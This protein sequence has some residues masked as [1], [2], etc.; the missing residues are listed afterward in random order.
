MSP[1]EL[2]ERYRLIDRA[3]LDF[4]AVDAELDV[5]LAGQS[6]PQALPESGG[7]NVETFSLMLKKGWALALSLGL[8]LAVAILLAALIIF[9][10]WR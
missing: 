4:F 9:A 2:G 6:S 5:L 1:V 8:V 7:E 3:R 10:G